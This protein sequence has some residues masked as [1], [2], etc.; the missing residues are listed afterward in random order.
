MRVDL[1]NKECKRRLAS[2]RAASFCERSNPISMWLPA[3]DKACGSERARRQM[4]I[5]GN[6]GYAS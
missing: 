6:F 3:A 2:R 4:R 5:E 1:A